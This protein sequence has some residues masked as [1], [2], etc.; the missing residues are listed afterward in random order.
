MQTAERESPRYAAIGEWQVANCEWIEGRWHLDGRP[1]HAGSQME[2]VFP[3]GTWQRIR[4][5]SEN[6]GKVLLAYVFY[7]G[8]PFKTKIGFTRK[9]RWPV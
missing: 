7:H 1:I 8:E 5:E 2:M 6:S 3:D 9:L 4:I